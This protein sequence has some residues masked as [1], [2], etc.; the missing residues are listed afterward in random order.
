MG[1]G[2]LEKNTQ[3]TQEEDVNFISKWP[4]HRQGSFLVNTCCFHG[5]KYDLQSEKKDS[6]SSKGKKRPLQDKMM[7]PQASH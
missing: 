3:E 1:R 5:C 2:N 6:E 7:Q 4:A